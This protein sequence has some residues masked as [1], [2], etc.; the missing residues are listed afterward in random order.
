[1]YDIHN[2][3]TKSPPQLVTMLNELF[4]LFDKI[5]QQYNL[6]KIKTIGDAYMAVGGVPTRR[7]DHAQAVADMALQAMEALKEFNQTNSLFNHELKIRIGIHTGP[8]VAGVVGKW[9]YIYDLYGETVKIAAAMESTGVPG[10]IQVSEETAKILQGAFELQE[11]GMIEVKTYGLRKTFFLVSRIQNHAIISTIGGITSND[12]KEKPANPKSLRSTES[13][14]SIS[15]QNPHW[16]WIN[17]DIEQ[18]AKAQV[19]D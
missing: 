10:R 11:R 7:N 18:L 12:K 9:K 17:H 15:V 14:F 2:S 19:S 3:L 4:S 6:E 13:N 1:M 8:C 5:C 16:K